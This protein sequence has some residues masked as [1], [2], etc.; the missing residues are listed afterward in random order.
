MRPAL[1]TCV[2]CLALTWAACSNAPTSP[3]STI[4][5]TIDLTGSWSGD[6]TVQ[7]SPALMRWTLAEPAGGTAVSGSALVSMP[8]GFVLLNGVLTGSIDGSTLTFSITVGAGGIPSQP[9]CS[10]R[11]DGSGAV[12]TA[13]AP[14]TLTGTLTVAA[15]SCSAPISNGPFT[16]SRS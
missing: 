15:S 9:A 3:P 14:P 12:A 8:D 6:L 5:S 7:G 1:L 10:G 16:L 13:T 4:V 11:I 2:G